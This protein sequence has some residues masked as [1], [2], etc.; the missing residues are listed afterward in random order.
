MQLVLD[1]EGMLLKV[2]NK[3]FYL[4]HGE[5]KKMISPSRVSSILVTRNILLSS[6]AVRLAVQNKIPLLFTDS[7]GDVVARMMSPMFNNLPSIRRYQAKAAQHVFSVKWVAA[8][9][10]LKLQGQVANLQYLANRK[11][12]SV[13]ILQAAIQ[14]TEEALAG[15]AVLEEQDVSVCLR[16]ISV[17]EAISA[18]R[19]WEA[20]GTVLEPPYAFTAR[21]RQP[22][23]DIFNAAINYLY[24]MLYGKVE[25]A[26][27]TVGLDPSLG[28]LHRDNYLTPSLAFDMIEALRP[29]ADRLLLEWCLQCTLLP[30]HVETRTEGGV[31]ISSYGKKMI[32]P[33]FNFWMEERCSFN[34]NVTAR[35]NHLLTLGGELV[36]QLRNTFENEPPQEKQGQ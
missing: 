4:V 28:F 32:I 23:K 33:A 8:I 25:S 16:K 19:Y 30:S 26:L 21:S 17:F 15:I 3:C 7:T 14:K 11:P 2:K 29:Q 5:L 31:W 20:V 27:L 18:A 22:A 6:A 36:N 13:A 24:G 10:K 34:G 12:G 1:T 35:K 9:I